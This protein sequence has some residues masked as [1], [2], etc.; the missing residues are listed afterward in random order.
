MTP[1]CARCKST[2]D[3]RLVL[4]DQWHCAKCVYELEEGDPSQYPKPR[5]RPLPLQ[6][7]TLFPAERYT[8]GGYAA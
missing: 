4:D 8:D 5:T 7:E 2:R 6:E 3:V 1:V